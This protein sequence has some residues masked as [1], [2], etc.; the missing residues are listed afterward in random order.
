MKQDNI[1][2]PENTV[3]EVE[4]EEI[5]DDDSPNYIECKYILMSSI[6]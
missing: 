1:Q 2:K 6:I 4:V 5:V 3:E